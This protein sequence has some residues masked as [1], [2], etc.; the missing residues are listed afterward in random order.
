[1]M[2]NKVTKVE[3]KKVFKRSFMYGSSWNYERMQNLGFLYTIL[4][5]LKKLYPDKDSASPAM[6]RHLE[7]FN[8]HQ[9][10]APFILGVTSAMEEQEGNEGAASITGIKVGLIGATGWSRR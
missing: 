7:F 1:M 10:A 6:K 8:T 5:V 3:L 2:N 4:P 9:T